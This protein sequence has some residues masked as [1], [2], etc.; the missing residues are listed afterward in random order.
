[1]RQKARKV[2][3][4]LCMAESEHVFKIL[5]G[6]RQSRRKLNNPMRGP[7]GNIKCCHLLRENVLLPNFSASS[8]FQI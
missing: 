5:I 8:S 7:N 1:M 4:V 3:L 2:F 6:K